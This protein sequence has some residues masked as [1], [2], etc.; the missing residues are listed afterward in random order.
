MD[1]FLQ[2]F[3]KENLLDIV[4]SVLVPTWSNGRC[5]KAGIAKR[6]DRFLMA[7]NIRGLVGRYRSWSYAVGYFDHKA[8]SLKLDFDTSFHLYP[9][10][11]N[12]IWLDDPKFC[13]LTSDGW[14][15]SV[16]TFH[17]SPLFILSKRLECLRKEVIRLEKAKRKENNKRL[18]EIDDEFQL[19]ALLINE[20]LFDPVR[21]K[22]L[23]KLESEKHLLLGKLE[24][25][26]RQKSGVIW[27][28]SGD[29]NT[30]FFHRFTNQRR[31]INSILE[32]DDGS[33][34]VES[35]ILLY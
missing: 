18:L 10:K 30:K 28:K 34:Q 24:E 21:L 29:N 9:F 19:L 7:E 25:S 27:V 14:A 32:V 8:V 26:W 16:D 33:G 11:F 2:L 22:L 35:M 20:D 31:L 1:F 12:P 15:D 3:D 4:P 17:G 5:G 6:L 13:A 23:T